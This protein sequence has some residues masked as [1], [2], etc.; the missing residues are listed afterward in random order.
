L[1]LHP[2]HLIQQQWEITFFLLLSN[3][4]YIKKHGNLYWHIYRDS[5][6]FLLSEAASRS[7]GTTIVLVNEH[8]LPT[9]EKGVIH[10]YRFSKAIGIKELFSEYMNYTRID[11][12]RD[13]KMRKIICIL[14]P[15]SP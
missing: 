4:S 9:I 5:L 7:H 8:H 10:G 1:L 11:I 6:D 13:I 14:A 3:M 15:Q 2:A 12:S